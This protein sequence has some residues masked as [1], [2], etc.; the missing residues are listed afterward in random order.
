MTTRQYEKIVDE[1]FER[2]SKFGIKTGPK[3]TIMKALKEHDKFVIGEDF[4]KGVTLPDG[5][6]IPMQFTEVIISNQLKVEQRKRAG[7]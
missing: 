7:L 4:V 6:G 1:A 5:S 2:F 3:H